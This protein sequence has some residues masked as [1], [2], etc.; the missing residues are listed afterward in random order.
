MKL[1]DLNSSVVKTVCGS[2]TAGYSDGTGNISRLSEPGGMALG[3]S[4]TLF[5]ADTNNNVIRVLDCSTESLTTLD[6]KLVPEPR[7]SPLN[8]NS[9]LDDVA[10]AKVADNLPFCSVPKTS[11]IGPRC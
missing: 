4:N 6:L 8:D 7:V 11:H 9:D 3:P 2:G 10:P 5:I 1:C